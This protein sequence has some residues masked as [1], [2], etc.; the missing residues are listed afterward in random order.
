MGVNAQSR[1]GKIRMELARGLIGE[2]QETAEQINAECWF[3]D[4]GQGSSNVILLGDGCAIVIDCGPQNSTTT[5]ELLK[6]Y[7]DFINVLVISHNDSDHDGGVARILENYPKAIDKIYFLSDR[8]S[9]QIRTF[10]LARREYEAGNLFDV[11]KRLEVN[12]QP[13]IIYSDNDKNIA[14]KLFYPDLMDSLKSEE[15]GARR[16]NRTSGV[17]GLFCGNRN[18]VYSSDATIVSWESIAEK[19]SDSIPLRCDVMAIP[20][21]GGRISDNRSEESQA[22]ERLYSKIITPQFGVISVGSSNQHG[23]PLAST[24]SALRNNNVKILCTQITP[25]CFDDLESIRPGLVKPFFGPS[26][27]TAKVRKTS[28]ARWSKDVGCVG[29]IVVE[30]S[31]NKVNVRPYNTLQREINQLIGSDNFHPLCQAN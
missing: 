29:S 1:L 25:R 8:T 22:Q 12:K 24:I 6:R 2:M 9:N 28:R 14:L 26:Q 15:S 10:R 4:V 16:A 3:L 31:P 30:V 20:H 7:V 19:M 21:H 27:S 5:I 17:L 11:P 13:Q 18:I 23:H